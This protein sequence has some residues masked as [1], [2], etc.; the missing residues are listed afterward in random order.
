MTKQSP[1]PA[2][3]VLDSLYSTRARTVVPP[4]Y[5]PAHAAANNISF[6]YGFA[7]P[8]VFPLET[9]QAA[10]AEAIASDP[11]GALNY[12]PTYAGLHDQVLA[13]LRTQGV[14]AEEDQ[15]MITYGSSQVLGLLPQ[16]FVDPGDTV[17]IEGP[18]F[19]GAVR[20]FKDAGASIVTVP[21]DNHGMDVDA[22]EQTL[23]DLRRKNVRPKF[24]YTIPTFQ[25]PTG[26]TMPLARRQRLL[27]LAAEYGVLVVEDDAYWDL[28]Y[29]GAPVP[30]LASL[31][32]SGLVVRVNTFSKILVPGV[33][34]GWVYAQPDII[35]R[36]AMF[37]I[38]GSSGP[39]LTRMVANACA[40]GK[41]DAH[42]QTLIG[43]YRT[44]RDLMLEAIDQYF[45]SDVRPIRPEGGFFLWCRLPEGM[46][47]TTLLERGQQH[48]VSFMP[49][50]RC[51]ANGQGED[52]IRLAFSY[53][54][55]EQ[56][57]E[58]I[59]RLGAA[60]HELGT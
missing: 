41:L 7:G 9:L 8:E 28:R 23:R 4:M 34:M 30:N 27:Q 37:K 54:P 2:A 58:G 42:I 53:L 46:Q 3:T 19:M 20:T 36:L 13:R 16:V 40:N 22:L 56:I 50:T 6:D 12:G 31:D 29:E 5:G 25:N 57:S 15:V 21:L 47:A 60:M 35:A 24:I 38:E 59:R 32:D 17:L 26:A 55:A 33:R 45:P 52:G 49:G 18:T 48:G 11:D 10:A 14:E 1:S 44:K 51:F 43:L 39:F